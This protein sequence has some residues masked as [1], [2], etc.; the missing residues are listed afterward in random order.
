MKLVDIFY[1]FFC[2]VAHEI[3][4]ARKKGEDANV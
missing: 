4:F 1:Q 2:A 3:T